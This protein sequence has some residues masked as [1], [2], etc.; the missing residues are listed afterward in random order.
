VK[1]A[2]NLPSAGKVTLIADATWLVCKESCIEGG[3]KLNIDLPVAAHSK[4]AN[5]ELFDKWRAQLPM[6]PEKASEVLSK[7]EPAIAAD[8]SPHRA[9]SIHWRQPPK[10][11]EWFP[12]ATEAAAVD[13]VKISHRGE[14]TQITYK[15]TVYKADQVPGGQ[16]DSV[17]V[18]EDA[19]GQRRGIVVPFAIT[20]KR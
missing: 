13:N 12:I 15:P 7:V 8:G 6:P 16:L 19:K 5:K 1:A 3:K 2:K 9:L 20:Q 17:L 18:Y 10:N 4:P 14:L 11:V